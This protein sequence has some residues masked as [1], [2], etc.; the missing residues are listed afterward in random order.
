MPRPEVWFAIPSANPENCA[1][2]LPAWRDMG[3]RVAI[4]QNG[5][6]AQISADRVVWADSYPGWAA[7]VNALC[8]SVVPREASIVVT[9]GDDM[10]PDPDRP[11]SDLG[12]EFLER[13]ADGFGVMQPCGDAA[14]GADRFCGSPWLGRA[15]IDRM[16]LGAGPMCAAYAHNWADTE[17]HWVARCMDALWMR[18]D[19]SQRHEHFA[20]RGG[21]APAYWRDS[22]ERTD[23]TDTRA[24][25]D[26][27]RRGFPGHEPLGE[28]RVFNESLF[29]REYDRRAER[30]WD[31]RHAGGEDGSVGCERMRAALRSCAKRGMRRVALY[32]AGRH[33]EKAGA[34][35]ARA[36]VEIV[37]II[38][39][40]PARAGTRMWGFPVATRCQ[41]EA[42]GLDGVVLSSDSAEE[43][44]FEACAGLRERGVEVVRLYAGGAAHERSGAMRSAA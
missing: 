13:F 5:T 27:A 29:A 21:E 23:A 34:A 2:T 18:P 15:W 44:L 6:R 26:R 11:A 22:V 33:T 1:R 37:C 25:I 40:D 41:A 35:I 24:F 3:Y 36:P 39:D 4:L 10:L 19:L 43:R 16:Y 8:R 28:G 7:S 32:G 30:H 38:D 17:L 12:E 31:G 14:S 9:G 20:L 42:M